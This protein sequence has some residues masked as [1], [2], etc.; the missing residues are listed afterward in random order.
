MT[1]YTIAITYRPAT[2]D[3]DLADT[4]IDQLTAGGTYRNV[5]ALE[6]HGTLRLLGNVD[7]DNGDLAAAADRALT[8]V[9][10]LRRAATLGEPVAI[11]ALT[12]AE[13]DRQ[14]DAS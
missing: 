12:D 13:F 6:Q 9:T 11:E 3:D 7:L 4:I 5:T 14:L 10:T 1:G 2:L 8:Q